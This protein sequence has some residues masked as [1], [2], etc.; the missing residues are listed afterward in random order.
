MKKVSDL[1][2]NIF[3]NMNKTNLKFI[4]M[5][6]NIP[7]SNQSKAAL[8]NIQSGKNS[9]SRVAAPGTTSNRKSAKSESS[10]DPDEDFNNLYAI[11]DYFP[12]ENVSFFFTVVISGNNQNVI[13]MGATDPIELDTVSADCTLQLKDGNCITG[14]VEGELV[15]WN[16]AT[17]RIVTTFHDQDMGVASRK[18]GGDNRMSVRRA[19]NGV[20]T[21]VVGSADSKL[22]MSGDKEGV[23]KVW[24]MTRKLLHTLEGHNS[25]VIA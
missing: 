7:R 11:L 6:K 5:S 25:Q 2:C 15:V 24:D 8:D 4:G 3:G 22:L 21:A 13:T 19:H 23:I 1:K 12:E 17:Q 14:T 9:P 18:G 10:H 16:A 20:I